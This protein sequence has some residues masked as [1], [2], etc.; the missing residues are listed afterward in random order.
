M[1]RG[2]RRGLSE[3]SAA[4]RPGDKLPGTFAAGPLTLVHC[5]HRNL[6]LQQVYP[7]ELTPRLGGTWVRDAGCGAALARRK[8][9]RPEFPPG[10]RGC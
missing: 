3:L 9:S 2:T 5:S 10:D 1:G 6:P 4:S 7:A 8:K